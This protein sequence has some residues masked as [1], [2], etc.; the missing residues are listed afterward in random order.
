MRCIIFKSTI[1][2]V[3]TS[4]ESVPSAQFF[5]I[6]IFTI[7]NA[8]GSTSFD[9]KKIF[10]IYSIFTHFIVKIDRPAGSAERQEVSTNDEIWL[11]SQNCSNQYQMNSGQ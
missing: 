10:L 8:K 2:N 5:T 1:L 11:R 6:P 4:V 3:N 9:V 7:H